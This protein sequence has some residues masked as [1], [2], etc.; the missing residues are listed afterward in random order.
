[1]LLRKV[2]DCVLLL[3]LRILDQK[4]CGRLVEM[5]IVLCGLWFLLIGK[6]MLIFAARVF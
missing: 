2:G 1:M 4:L 6:W 5:R 3:D